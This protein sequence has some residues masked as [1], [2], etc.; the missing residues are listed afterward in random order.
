MKATYQAKSLQMFLTRRSQQGGPSINQ[1]STTLHKAQLSAYMMS[2]PVNNYD[3][4]RPASTLDAVCDKQLT[5]CSIQL[6]CRLMICAGSNC[7]SR[8]AHHLTI[9]RDW[10]GASQASGHLPRRTADTKYLGMFHRRISRE[11][12]VAKCLFLNFGTSAYLPW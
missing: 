11:L 1:A 6:R 3:F 8:I 7:A 9:F 4:S 12:E 2:T 10:T 5:N